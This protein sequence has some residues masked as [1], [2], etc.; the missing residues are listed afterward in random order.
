MCAKAPRP[1]LKVVCL[2]F[3]HIWQK[4]QCQGMQVSN[5]NASVYLVTVDWES[6]QHWPG[7]ACGYWDMQWLPGHLCCSVKQKEEKKKS[8]FIHIYLPLCFLRFACRARLIKT[9]LSWLNWAWVGKSLAEQESLQAWR[10]STFCRG[11]VKNLGG[12]N[13]SSR[14]AQARV[15]QK[16]AHCLMSH[17]CLICCC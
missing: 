13:S 1:N 11:T 12:M 5:S 4:L 6:W 3:N 15:L 2:A 17:P 14:A 9:Q 7:C 10:G 16:S 8:S